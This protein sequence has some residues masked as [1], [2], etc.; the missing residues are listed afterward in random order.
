V[1]RGAYVLADPP[2]GA[3]PRVVI[4]S[5]GSEVALALRAHQQLA[6]QGVPSRVVSM[7]SMELFA[8]ESME[9]QKSVLLDGVPRVSIEAGS[10]MSWYRWVGSN[11]VALGLTRF[12]ASAPYERIYEELGI[13][14][15]KLV[16]TVKGL[17]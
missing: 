2:G 8:R 1:T 9:Y 16:D 15:Q 7:P 6:E 4:M 13:T 12:G 17:V 5:S 11:G 10:P 3:T 14:V